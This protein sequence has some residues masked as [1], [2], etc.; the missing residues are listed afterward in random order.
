MR[1]SLR[2]AALAAGILGLP[3]SSPAAAKPKGP[4]GGEIMKK[5]DCL[6]CHQVKRKVVGPPF[7]DIAKKYKGDKAAVAT[8]VK[9]VKDGGSGNWGPVPMAA[10]PTVPDDDILAMVKYVLSQK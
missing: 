8:L 4:D 9:K 7:V 1:L 10:H 6:S 3:L 5:Y 2:A